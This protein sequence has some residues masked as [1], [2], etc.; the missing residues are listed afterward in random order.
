MD[1]SNCFTHLTSIFEYAYGH[2]TAGHPMQGNLF[3]HGLY[4]LQNEISDIDLRN[5]CKAYLYIS[6]LPYVYVRAGND[7]YIKPHFNWKPRIEYSDLYNKSAYKEANLGGTDLVPYGYVLS[8]GAQMWRRRYMEEHNKKEPI[9]VLYDNKTYYLTPGFDKVWIGEVGVNG[10]LNGLTCRRSYEKDGSGHYYRYDNIVKTEDNQVVVSKLIA[11]FCEFVD[12]DFQ[13]IKKS[14]E[15]SVVRDSD[16]KSFSIGGSYWFNTLEKTLYPL[17]A[18]NRMEIQ[19]YLRGEKSLGGYKITNFVGNYVVAF[20]SIQSTRNTILKA[21]YTEENDIQGVFRKVFLG[22]AISV[23]LPTKISQNI[24]KDTLKKYYR[25]FANGLKYYAMDLK[26][27]QPV[28]YAEELAED[29]RDLRCELY[30]T[31]KNIWDRWAC[32][33]YNQPNGRDTF[34]VNKFFRNNFVFIDSFYNN[35][36]DTMKLNCNKLLDYYN[37]S[38][39]EQSKLG[40]S[41]VN[42]LGDI[43]G[44]HGCMMFNFP[45]NV[46]FSGL[47]N[48]GNVTDEELVEHMSD[49][50]KPVPV[51]RVGDIEYSNKFTVIY[52]RSGSKL[53]TN[54]RNKFNSDT[55]DIW[56]YD[57]GT[58]IAPTTFR[59]ILN[60]PGKTDAERLSPEC[61]IAYKVPSFGVAYSRQDNSFWKNIDV[62]M[63]NMS[64]TEQSVKAMAYITDKGSSEK[65]NVCYYGQDLFSIY[66]TYSYMVTVEMMGDAQIQPLMYFQLMN[67]PMFRGTYMI[68][69]VEHS[70]TPGMMTTKFTGMKMSKVQVPFTEAWFTTPKDEDFVEPDVNQDE[71]DD[72]QDKLTSNDDGTLIDLADNKF[73]RAIIEAMGMTG[74]NDKW[75]DVFVKNVYQKYSDNS[76]VIDGELIDNMF[77]NIRNSPDWRTNKFRYP[78]MMKNNWNSLTHGAVRPKVGDLLFGYHDNVTAG[79]F[80]HVAIYLGLHGGGRYVAEGLS[81]GGTDVFNKTN[82]IQIMRIENSRLAKDS[83]VICYFSHC[84]KCEVE[85]TEKSKQVIVTQQSSSGGSSSEYTPP[86]SNVEIKT[87]PINDAQR[88]QNGIYIMKQL[89]DVGFTLNGNNVKLTPMQAAAI[90]GVWF[91]ESRW[92][93]TI[94]NSSSKAY[95]L[96][97]WLGARK[98]NNYV[99]IYCKEKGITPKVDNASNMTTIQEELEYAKWEFNR[100]YYKNTCKLWGEDAN[101]KNQWG[102][103]SGNLMIYKNNMGYDDNILYDLVYRFTVGYENGDSPSGSEFAV[104]NRTNYAKTAYQLYINNR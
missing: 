19:K 53:D 46:N 99:N 86:N 77:D 36:Y 63:D 25:G 93:P 29:E 65:K 1:T 76:L 59:S 88:E 104:N 27:S 98:Y 66:Q 17:G 28:E 21:L 61:R 60:G 32:G 64:V 74:D 72:G 37:G 13:T 94:V 4:Y 35:I 56:S 84:T 67:I 39:S 47:D 71:S 34:K 54:D 81:V 95:G 40:K 68:I 45:D 26:A 85:Q 82:G 92:N 55:F 58:E 33:Y 10:Y 44:Q 2:G 5:K 30:L 73:S 97:Q 62:S 103:K 12:G 48:D 52:T 96:A 43:V 14:C 6:S 90:A 51:N 24:S 3:T 57:D 38:V 79:K 69:K 91:Q 8:I 42:H 80:H 70:L 78:P 102:W 31:L 22:E 16:N 15:L 89:V 50:F 49:M 75:C 11:L 9:N 18:N 100:P 41:I 87:I 101:W 7:S 83:D 20:Y 23:F